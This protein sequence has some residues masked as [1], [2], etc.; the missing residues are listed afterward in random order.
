MRRAS[1]EAINKTRTPGFYP[2]QFK[3][4]VLMADGLLHNPQNWNREFHRWVVLIPLSTRT[5]D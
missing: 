4:A 3:E 2:I 5:H 1:H